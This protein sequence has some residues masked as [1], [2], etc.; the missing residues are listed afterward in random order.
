[1]EEA[2][3]IELRVS[4]LE[5]DL[6]DSDNEEG[7]RQN[8]SVSPPPVPAISST[9]RYYLYSLISTKP[10]SPFIGITIDFTPK[11]MPESVQDRGLESVQIAGIGILIDVQGKVEAEAE[12][13]IVITAVDGI[14]SEV[15]HEIDMITIVPTTAVMIG[16][17]KGNA[18]AEMTGRIRVGRLD[19]NVNVKR[20]KAGEKKIAKGQAKRKKAKRFLRILKSLR[21]TL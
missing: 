15:V 18:I 14:G 10:S 2:N 12:A 16:S 20:P 7:E 19:E 13:E 9:S 6:D 1:M 21:R 3:E 17:G 4:A 11:G 5:E 8:S